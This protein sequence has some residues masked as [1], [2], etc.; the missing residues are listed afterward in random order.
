MELQSLERWSDVK[1]NV[2]SYTSHVD[3]DRYS[4]GL[5]LSIGDWTAKSATD[6]IDYAA[7][8]DFA[9]AVLRETA[10]H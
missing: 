4:S 1:P 9:A 6:R 7:L 5:D 3:D 2:E 10:K 8:V